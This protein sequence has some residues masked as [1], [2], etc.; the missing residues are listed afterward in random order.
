MFDSKDIET[1]RSVKAP[2]GLFDRIAT[3]ASAPKKK[4]RVFENVRFMRSASAIAAC[5]LLVMTLTFMLGRETSDLYIC[6][7]GESL[8]QAGETMKVGDAPTPLAR[9]AEE[10]MG[11]PFE[12]GAKKEVTVALENGELWTVGVEGAMRCELPYTAEAGEVLYL[13]P[14]ADKISYLTL[15][16]NG[17]SVT[18]TVRAGEDP[19]DSRI[20]FE[21][22]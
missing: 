19:A 5:F 8:R 1:Y 16:E 15:T 20:T 7:G 18:Y 11:I 9:I 6:V 13:L 4:A 12:I 22:Q 2:E 17:V 21:K 10:P 3:D 14:E